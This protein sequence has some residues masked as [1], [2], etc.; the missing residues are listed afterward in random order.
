MTKPYQRHLPDAESRALAHAIKLDSLQDEIAALGYA[1]DRWFGWSIEKDHP[2]V[3]I[4]LRKMLDEDGN[5]IG[6]VEE[7][8]SPQ[9]LF[10]LGV[11]RLKELKLAHLKL[12]KET[13]AGDGVAA[14]RKFMETFIE[15]G[16]AREKEAES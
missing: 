3:Q 8:L 12:E 7:W 1:L 6:S 15:Q 13:G 16:L 9:Q 10:L 2:G 5:W 4:K 14:Y 11:G